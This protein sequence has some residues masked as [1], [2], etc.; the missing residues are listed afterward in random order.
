MHA[1][2]QA[3][4]T[5]ATV[6]ADVVDKYDNDLIDLR[7]DL[8]AH[9]ELS[10]SELRTAE[11]VAARVEQAGWQVTR[12]SR[13]GFAADLG[14]GGPLVA[15]RADMDALPVHDLTDDPWASTVAGRRPRLRPRR[16]HHRADRRRRWRWP[17]CTTAGCCPAG[18]G[19]CSSRPR[20]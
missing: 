16:A 4:S 5:A 2:D 3:A 9:P 1:Q 11:L 15:L 12:Y 6:I 13:T 20:R 14:D 17:R 7:R 19:C 18:C 8:H 10:W